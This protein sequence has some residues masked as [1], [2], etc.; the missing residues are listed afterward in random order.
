MIAH[1]W[2]LQ[3]VFQHRQGTVPA[4]QVGL[5]PHIDHRQQPQPHPS[6]A[7]QV[8]VLPTREIRPD[9]PL[10]QGKLGGIEL[11]ACLRLRGRSRIHP[12]AAGCSAIAIAQVEVAEERP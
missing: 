12:P 11:Q 7:H 1:V 5:N 3:A 9:E 6:R 8:S 10:Q 2:R 4:L